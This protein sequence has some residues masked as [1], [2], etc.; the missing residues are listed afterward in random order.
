L[1]PLAASTSNGT[2]VKNSSS[3]VIDFGLWLDAPSDV[4]DFSDLFTGRRRMDGELEADKNLY[5]TG[6]I[7]TIGLLLLGVVWW[8]ALI[9]AGVAAI[10]WYLTYGRRIII[11]I[12]LILLFFGL[13]SWTGL[14][15]PPV[16][17]GQFLAAL[18]G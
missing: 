10:S 17:W 8:K 18:R 6:F 12:G 3:L 7:Y 9:V 11:S 15:P 5:W 14:I 2:T 13:G 16:Q 4:A 1:S